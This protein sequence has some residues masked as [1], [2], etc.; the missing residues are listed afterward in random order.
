MAG[1]VYEE[2]KV[3][4]NDKLEPALNVLHYE[5]VRVSFNHVAR[6]AYRMCHRIAIQILWAAQCLADILYTND[7]KHI[8]KKCCLL[9]PSKH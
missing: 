4:S 6:Q 9:H 7:S 1:E 3:N 5:M 2:Q 8:P